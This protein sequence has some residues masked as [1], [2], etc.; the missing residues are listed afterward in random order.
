MVISVCRISGGHQHW[1][2]IRTGQME[3]FEIPFRS[4]G[5]IHEAEEAMYCLR[6]GL[7]ESN[8]MPLDESLKIMKILDTLRKQWG[9]KY[10]QEK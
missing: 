9:L 3:K 8:V 1:N 4:T 5:Y 10:P 2:Y 7:T 6:E